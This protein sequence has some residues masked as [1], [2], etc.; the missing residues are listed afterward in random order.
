[1]NA[2]I[3]VHYYSGTHIARLGSKTASA[4]AS[5]EAA[6][7]AVAQKAGLG[8][9]VAIRPLPSPGPFRYRFVASVPEAQDT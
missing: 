8:K 7:R 5:P 9:H 2:I 6:A 3:T 4:T 1:M